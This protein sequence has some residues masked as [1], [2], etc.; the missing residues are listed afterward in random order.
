M[1]AAATAPVS[2]PVLSL[3]LAHTGCRDID[4]IRAVSRSIVRE[5]EP[6]NGN[7][8]VSF[9]A[10]ARVVSGRKRKPTWPKQGATHSRVGLA[11]PV[12]GVSC[13]RLASLHTD[14]IAAGH[15]RRLR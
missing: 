8:P 9:G 10:F 13:Q 1:E 14:G 6:T 2:F 12:A 4:E 7:L 5:V 3:T 11:R 15:S